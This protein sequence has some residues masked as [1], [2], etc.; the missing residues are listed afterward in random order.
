MLL[1]WPIVLGQV[2]LVTSGQECPAPAAI[3]A[4]VREMLGAR[5]S[6]AFE[7]RAT[8]E[9]DGA[10]LRVR[11][12]GKDERVL[13]DRV[14]VAEGTCDEL[15]SVVA[16]VLATW[17]SDV[18]PVYVGSLPEAAPPDAPPAAPIAEAVAPAAGT[19][20]SRH[21]AIGAALGADFSAGK[22]APLASLGARWMPVR[23][24]L[25][26]AAAATIIGVRSEPLST[27][28][29]RYWRWPFTIGPAYRLA[30]GAASLDLQAG[31]ALAWFH[32]AGTSF[33]SALTHDALLGGGFVAARASGSWNGLEPFVDVT[34]FF[35]RPTEAFVQRDV[36]QP[37][38][39]LPGLELHLAVGASLRAW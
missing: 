6:D 21:V 31:A 16:V 23:S 25:G 36:D 33:P 4:R 14:L 12:R 18:H 27:G 8:V 17:L 37:S 39:R 28:S 15:A 3:D 1:Y 29:V 30:V 13:G 32:V 2:L 7:E 34:G 9:R 20:P 10:S 22:P 19:P 24:G 26:A 38:V 11:L 5:P 35:W